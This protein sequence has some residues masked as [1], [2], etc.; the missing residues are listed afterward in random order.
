MVDYKD[1][2]FKLFNKMTDIAEEIQKF[3]QKMEEEVI[4]D[5]DNS[6]TE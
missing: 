1:L 5:E 4:N 2:Y 3:Q 6:D